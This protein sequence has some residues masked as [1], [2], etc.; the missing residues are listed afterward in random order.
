MRFFNN[1]GNYWTSPDSFGPVVQELSYTAAASYALHSFT[2]Y[3]LA[4]SSST[5]NSSRCIVFSLV[6]L[7]MDPCFSLIAAKYVGL[8]ILMCDHCTCLSWLCHK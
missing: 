6:G 8:Y 1:I 4:I 2:E 5:D 7:K 3:I